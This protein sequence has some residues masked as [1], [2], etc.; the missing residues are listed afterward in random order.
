MTDFKEALKQYALGVGLDLVGVCSSEPF[1]RYISEL[2]KRKEY[3]TGRFR[4]RIENWKRLADPGAV[5]AGAR[6]VVVIGFY[7]FTGEYTA[8]G[9]ERGR[10]GRIVSHGHIGV[11]K[12]ARLM[13]KYLN[14]H[15]YKAV[16]GAHRKEA[17]VRA[18][19]GT[20]GKHGLV[21]NRK[22]GSWVAYQSIVT[23][24]AMSP[25]KPDEK[26]FCDHCIDCLDACPTGALYEPYRLDPRRC[27]TCL[28]T[29]A[30]IDEMYWEKIPNYIMGCDVCQESC[31]VNRDLEP[32]DGIES[33]FPK[34]LGNA[35]GLERMLDLS[36]SNFQSRI[37]AY[38]YGKVTESRI[39]GAFM[40]SK[41]L[42]AFYQKR[43][44]AKE[45]GKERVPE[46]FV[47]A[48]GNLLAYQR[49]AIIAIGNSRNRR[50]AKKL[51]KLADHPVLGRYALWAI[52]RTK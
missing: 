33:I 7:F 17:A 44:K 1:D 5:L 23:D 14:K 39:T 8:A 9:E 40:R 2:E 41:R 49:N 38:I 34:F 13:V 10:F 45:E 4:H 25:D 42:R 19:L 24:A 36:E 12:R 20:I 16:M 47:Y 22:Y 52:E 6:S 26:P 37:L 18:G 46:T 48:A 43:L 31:P 11:L 50:L 35:P 21:I 3:Y 28:L 51:Y 32:K 15:G 30:D 29:G 27:A